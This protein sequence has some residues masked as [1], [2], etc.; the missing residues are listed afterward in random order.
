MIFIRVKI[1][2]IFFPLVGLGACA[3]MGSPLEFPEADGAALQDSKVGILDYSWVA[4]FS[5][6]HVD[7]I[8]ASGSLS[9]AGDYYGY[10]RLKPGNH[11][12]ELKRYPSEGH[13]SYVKLIL[14]V[15]AGHRYLMKFEDCYWC[16]RFRSTGW[17][18]DEGSGEVVSGILPDWSFWQI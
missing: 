9:Y 3:L 4:R 1:F 5:A 17:I 16:G 18:I 10:A 2:F 15:E 12:I 7:G 6:I 8:Y 13:R 14:N 11:T